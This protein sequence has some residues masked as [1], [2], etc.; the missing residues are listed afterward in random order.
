[1]SRRTLVIFSSIFVLILGSTGAAA[2]Q[3]DKRIQKKVPKGVTAGGIDLSNLTMPEAAERLSHMTSL[4]QSKAVK[5][6]S[7]E[8]QWSLGPK[9][10]QVKFS[11]NE[12]LQKVRALNYQGSAFSRIKRQLTGGSIA[13]EVPLTSSYSS[14]AATAFVE[15]VAKDVDRS[16]KN[17]D[18]NFSGGRFVVVKSQSGKTLDRKALT[19]EVKK[20]LQSPGNSEGITAKV[21]TVPAQ[22]GDSQVKQRFQTVLVANRNTFKLTVYKNLKV[23]KTYGISVGAEGHST[24]PG[25]YSIASKDPNPAWHV[26]NSKWAGK[27]A[28][29]VVPA[30]D[31]KNPIK[32]R[33]L[34]IAAG[35]GIHGTSDGSSIGRAASHGCLRMHVPDV[36]DLYPRIPVGAPIWIL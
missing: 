11:T 27:L 19:S 31:P 4:K 5:V 36:I 21:K 15:R 3:W 20:A 10:A 24:P 7:G 8:K 26:P 25:R 22:V 23:S 33:W 14:A 6:T 12:T 35:V 32:A 1:M 30:G 13:E 34:G 16:P 2:V 17:A 18:I 28:G 9:T 29:T